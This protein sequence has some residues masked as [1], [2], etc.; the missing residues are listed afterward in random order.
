MKASSAHSTGPI[1]V[2]SGIAGLSTALGLEGAMVITGGSLR[3]GS[4]DLAQGGIAAAVGAGDAPLRHAADT[5]S[6]S[7]GI[8]ERDLAR[9][10]AGAAPDRISWLIGLGARFDRDDDGSLVLGR[11]A[12]HATHRIV[13]AGGDA[14]GAEVMR[15]MRA[16]VHARSDIDIAEGRHLVDLLLD[17]ERVVGVLTIDPSGELT[18]FV[19]P[20]VV[21]ATG[22]VGRVFARTTNPLDIAA[23]GL[24]AAARAGAVL[25][26]LEFVQ[27]HPT[28][29]G[30]TADPALLLTEALRGAGAVLVDERGRRFMADEHPDAELAPRDVVARGIWRQLRLGRQPLLDATSAVGDAFPEQFP[31]A[32]EHAVAAGFDPRRQPL[33]VEPAEHYHMGGIATDDTGR[34]SLRGLWA[35]GEVAATGLHG[36]NRL[37]SNSLLE[38]LVIGAR[39]AAAIEPAPR[40]PTQWRAPRR[41][42]DRIADPA[43]ETAIRNTMWEHAGLIRDDDGLRRATRRLHAVAGPGVAVTAD[44]RLTAMLIVERALARTESRGAHF[45]S[46]YPAPDPAWGRRSLFVPAP[47][48]DSQAA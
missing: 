12:G 14:T 22:G 40:P 31:T 11:E 37:A 43:S 8:G 20:A 34:T 28:T 46:D 9:I 24:A 32:W 42:I 48:R 10:V 6:V 27:F 45:R 29:L 26:D 21:L 41:R 35:V 5:I 1:V 3:S 44:L 18:A 47:Y 15:A 13:H 4:S 16:A 39:A 2:G 19:A 30:G 17:D 25:A 38:G 7:G 23:A 33:P 36:A